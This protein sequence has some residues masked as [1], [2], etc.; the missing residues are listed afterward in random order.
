MEHEPQSI[1]ESDLRLA[2]S[3]LAH[4]VRNASMALGLSN[5]EL[6]PSPRENPL[7]LR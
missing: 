1:A 4:Y 5:L 7:L 2:A 3:S 6:S